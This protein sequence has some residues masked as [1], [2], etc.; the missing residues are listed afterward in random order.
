MTSTDNKN[1]PMYGES[2]DDNSLVETC[3]PLL[4]Q[5]NADKCIP[6]LLGQYFIKTIRHS[7]IFQP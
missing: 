4:Y 2:D 5:I 6:V 7:N 3:S 1:V